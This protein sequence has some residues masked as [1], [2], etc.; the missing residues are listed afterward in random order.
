[1]GEEVVPP[2]GEWGGLSLQEII[3]IGSQQCRPLPNRLSV[4]R[5]GKERRWGGGRNTACACACTFLC[6]REILNITKDL[7]STLDDPGC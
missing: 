6:E 3:P 7:V 1:M 2:S 5:L 4:S